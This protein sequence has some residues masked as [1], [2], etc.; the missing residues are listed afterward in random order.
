MVAD[1]HPPPRWKPDTGNWGEDPPPP[2]ACIR[3][4]RKA[5]AEL[6]AVEDGWDDRINAVEN[7]ITRFAIDYIADLTQDEYDALL[8]KR[9][10]LT[11]SRCR[12][13]ELHDN[14]EKDQ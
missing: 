1:R 13:R 2:P 14:W 4:R 3:H 11:R 12:L 10:C 5:L 6:L 7:E 8:E 9:R